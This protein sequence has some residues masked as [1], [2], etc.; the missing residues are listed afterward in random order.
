MVHKCNKC[1]MP[2][3]ADDEYCSRCTS[4]SDSFGDTAASSS[5]A[6]VPVPWYWDL[7]AFMFIAIPMFYLASLSAPNTQH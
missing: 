6:Q 1:G 4:S 7:P 5:N 3:D 2:L